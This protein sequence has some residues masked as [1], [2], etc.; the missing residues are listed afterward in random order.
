MSRH[1][2]KPA[3][4]P[5]I[6]LKTLPTPEPAPA[7]PIVLKTLPTPKPEPAHTHMPEPA[8]EP[9]PEGKVITHH[10][11]SGLLRPGDDKVRL[12]RQDEIEIRAQDVMF[13]VAESLQAQIREKREQHSITD[14]KP[15]PPTRA[16]RKRREKGDAKDLLDA[17]LDRL[18][19]RGP[20]GLTD[21]EI[22]KEA[23]VSRNTF[24]RHAGKDGSLRKK[25]LLYRRKSRGRGPGRFSD[26]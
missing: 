17:T 3:P 23:S 7:P 25:L 10:G 13:Q 6:V 21:E 15:N 9:M 18:T 11:Y 16:A 4:A 1:R 19:D 24:Y 20:W 14:Q 8:P 12:D 5:P 22:F 26:V 2:S